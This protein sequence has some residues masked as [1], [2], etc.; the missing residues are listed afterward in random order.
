MRIRRFMVSC[1][2][3][4]TIFASGVTGAFAAPGDGKGPS[5]C[6]EFAP[7][8]FISFVARN[9]GH[10]AENNPGNAQNDSPPFVPFIVGCNPNA[11]P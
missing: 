11:Q 2:F 6:K 1:A 7:G 5:V 8:D 10:S 9:I 3:A 4:T